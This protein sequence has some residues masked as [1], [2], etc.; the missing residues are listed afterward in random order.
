M[1]AGEK[2]YANNVTQRTHSVKTTIAVN[3]IISG[4]ELP[5]DDVL[6]IHVATEVDEYFKNSKIM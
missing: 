4:P 3:K 6:A 5:S 1:E 2:A